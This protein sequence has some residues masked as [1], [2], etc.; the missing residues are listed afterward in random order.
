[1]PLRLLRGV[2][3]IG[4]I[5]L[6]ACGARSGV[7]GNPASQAARYE[8]VVTTEWLRDG[9]TMKLLDDFIYVDDVGIRW[10]A[11]KGRSID[12]ASIPK[13]LWW[14]G[15]PY[16]GEYREASVV[17]DIYCAETRK[18]ATWRAVHRMF[19]EAML[20]SG[21]AKARALIMYGAVYRH[22]PRWA[23]PMPPGVPSPPP[24]PKTSTPLEEDVKRIETLVN[25]GEVTS[26][27]A[28]EALPLSI[29]P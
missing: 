23:D 12:G 2:V 10:V 14:S 9:R 22:G 8:G 16:E 27:E 3:A 13:A 17:H 25:S 18:T 7:S 5:S 11:P 29:P 21:V 28:I 6:T 4:L 24:A 19:Y 20:T 1:M 15:G 26:P